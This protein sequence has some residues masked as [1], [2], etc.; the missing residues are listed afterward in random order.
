MFD[1]EG[2]PFVPEGGITAD[3]ATDTAAA[4]DGPGPEGVVTSDDTAGADGGGDDGDRDGDD[5]DG[6]G[7]SD[8][9]PA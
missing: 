7:L 4:T 3:D 2:D 6:M 5:G 1:D 8:K 9:V